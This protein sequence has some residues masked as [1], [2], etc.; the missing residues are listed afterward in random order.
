MKDTTKKMLLKVLAGL[1][2]AGGSAAGIYKIAT[3]E[4]EKVKKFRQTT[5]DIMCGGVGEFIGSVGGAAL[6]TYS[7][8]EIDFRDGKWTFKSENAEPEKKD[9]PEFARDIIDPKEWSRMTYTSQ[10][11]YMQMLEKQ[12]AF[13]IRQKELDVEKAKAEAAAANVVITTVKEE[14]DHGTPNGQEGTKQV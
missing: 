6:R 12:N 14:P 7:K 1:G 10:Q 2:I 8:G 5:K 9:I 11:S 13:A 3:S 4:N